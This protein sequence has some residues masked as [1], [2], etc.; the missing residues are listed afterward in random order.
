MNEEGRIN[1]ESKE[2]KIIWKAG[3]ENADI[4]R[5]VHHVTTGAASAFVPPAFQ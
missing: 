1:I 2:V 5:S 3:E 4:I